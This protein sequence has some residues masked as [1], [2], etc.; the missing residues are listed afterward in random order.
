MKKLFAVILSLLTIATLT[1]C[2]SDTALG[3]E[4]T[5]DTPAVTA[6]ETTV[7]TTTAPDVTVAPKE[8]TAETEVTTTETEA[9]TTIADTLI[10]EAPVTTAATKAETTTTAAN[11]SNIII[12]NGDGYTISVDNSKWMNI[13]SIIDFNEI[14]EMDKSGQIDVEQLN[15]TFNAFYY[16]V[17]DPSVMFNVVSS[18]LSDEW[19]NKE[20]SSVSYSIC[21]KIKLLYEQS[22]FTYEGDE[23]IKVNGYDCLKLDFSTNMLAT[24]NESVKISSFIFLNGDCYYEAIF[25]APSSSYDKCYPDFE[26]SLNSITFTK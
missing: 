5:T 24:N 19:K 21:Q 6:E 9:T 25:T 20:L 17:A 26:K 16:H 22:G 12:V 11:A 23:L 4:N 10:T 14:A 8:T 3:N 1:A 18:K 13:S 15:E 7:E 2:K